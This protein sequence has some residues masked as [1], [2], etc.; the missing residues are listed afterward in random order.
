MSFEC[1]IWDRLILKPEGGGW[2]SWRDAFSQ[3]SLQHE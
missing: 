1:K 3:G 2:G